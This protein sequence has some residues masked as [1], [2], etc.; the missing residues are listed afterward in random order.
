MQFPKPWELQPIT[1]GNDGFG[2]VL[3]NS[4]FPVFSG[5]GRPRQQP[6]LDGSDGQ[7]EMDLGHRKI[8]HFR[9]KIPPQESPNNPKINQKDKADPS[10]PEILGV[11]HWENGIMGGVFCLA[12][13]KNGSFLCCFPPEIPIWAFIIPHLF[14]LSP[15]SPLF[16]PPDFGM[17]GRRTLRGS[18]STAGPWK[19][20]GAGP[21][22]AAPNTTPGSAREPGIAISTLF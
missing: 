7:R 12:P 11:S 16:S 20:T 1:H 10:K 4:A 9:V 13:E 15:F 21:T 18:W 6:L 8:S 2:A 17:C 14:S 22:S 5:E 19:P 3:R